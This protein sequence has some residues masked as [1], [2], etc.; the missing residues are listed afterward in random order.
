VLIYM[1]DQYK[2]NKNY[3]DPG[4]EQIRSH[5]DFDFIL[6]ESQRQAM[7]EGAPISTSARKRST[8]FYASAIAASALLLILISTSVFSS[9]YEEK[10]TEYFAQ[11]HY[12]NPPNIE[13]AKPIF[14]SYK[15]PAYDGGVIE[16]ESGS[17]ITIPKEAFEYNN[18]KVVTGQVDILYRE[19][20]DFID[21][22][23]SGVPM[24]YDSL[25]Q[26]YNLE[27]AGMVEIFAEQGGQR[28]NI[29][30]GKSLEV[31]LVSVVEV[32][33]LNVPPSF[34]IYKLNETERKWEYTNID[35]I[36]Y[37]EVK[38]EQVSIGHIAYEFQKE[39]FDRLIEL[40]ILHKD[41]LKKVNNSIPVPKEPVRPTQQREDALV[42]NFDLKSQL[43]EAAPVLYGAYKDAL[44]QLHSSE[45]IQRSELDHQWETLEL[46]Q[47][48]ELDFKLTLIASDKT[49]TILINPLL[50][51]S[52][53]QKAMDSY[54][55]A[56]DNYSTSMNDWEQ[57]IA[58]KK[59]EIQENMQAQKSIAQ[60][61]YKENLLSLQTE[62]NKEDILPL[63]QR[64]KV[65][66]KFKAD[67]LGI[68]NCDR[69]VLP[70][71]SKFTAK[72]KLPSGKVLHNLTGY[73][74]CKG[75]NTVQKF[76]VDRKTPMHLDLSKEYLIWLVLPDNKIA[77]LKPKDLKSI[78]P[79]E[80][81]Q[82][83]TL[84]MIEDVDIEEKK[85]RSTLNF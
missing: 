29:R 21:F 16:H 1:R 78:D 8:I 69:P 55:N 19:F 11:K 57:K 23:L 61:N 76:L 49:Q 60:K 41:L 44:W 45:K 51:G 38:P 65:V 82:Q 14:A 73:M 80:S 27:S 9:S 59:K 84:S 83:F 48:N 6:K 37:L 28:I 77:L 74:A 4:E 24:T 7:Q 10:Q 40:E 22:F 75:Q 2:F 54:G 33:N 52:A 43:K 53:F 63:I 30:P 58:N 66:N 70:E 81:K 17:K 5:M 32:P 68:W 64:T 39:Y 71:L 79:K 12:V 15:V 72:F 67:E 42:F 34:N 31:E 47:L 26:T 85:L 3:K 20:H 36:E 18:G 46:V 13:A 56:L 35:N 50:V 25:G 62:N